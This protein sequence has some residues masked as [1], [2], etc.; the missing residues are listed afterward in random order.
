MIKWIDNFL[1]KS[2]Y[3]SFDRSGFI[4]HQRDFNE[5]DLQYDMRGKFA[6]ITGGT[7]GIGIACARAF[8]MRG[9]SLFLIGRDRQRGEKC[10]E[11]IRREYPKVDVQFL[12]LDM[13]NLDEVCRFANMHPLPPIDILVNNAGGMPLEKKLTEQ[14]LEVIFASQVLGHFLLTSL[15]IKRGLL[16]EKARVIFVSSGGMYTQKLD[17]SDLKWEKHPYNHYQA[18]A[19]AKRAQVILTE[20]FV[21]KYPDRGLLFSCMHPGWVDTPGV[22][23]DM[24]W[25]YWWMRKRLR[26]V[27]QGADTIIW[28]AL[29]KQ[30]Y[31]NGKFWFDRKE[32]PVHLYSRTQS[33]QADAERLWKLCEDEQEKREC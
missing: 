30:I 19:N 20:L 15:L 8:A 6:L 13:S 12:A 1:D 29:K 33:N 25:F 11:L 21:K 24:P 14:G 4:R 31:P 17:L 9:I 5:D 23:R 7:S 3:F 32:A 27:E 22:E 16:H 2:I 26:A 28:L 18:Y 10:V